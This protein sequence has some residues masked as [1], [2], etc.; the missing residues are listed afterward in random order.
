[1]EQAHLVLFI[2]LN[3]IR[4]SQMVPIRHVQPLVIFYEKGG[5]SMLSTIKM[6]GLAL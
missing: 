5:L 4:E 2:V 6:C 3:L 1:M